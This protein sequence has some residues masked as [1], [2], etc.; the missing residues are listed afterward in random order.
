MGHQKRLYLYRY[1]P[2]KANKEELKHII[3]EFR[4]AQDY[5][6]TY[7]KLL[8]GDWLPRSCHIRS[9]LQQQRLKQHVSNIILKSIK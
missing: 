7:K 4:R 6:A 5:E 3:E 9:K 1:R 8:N 2:I